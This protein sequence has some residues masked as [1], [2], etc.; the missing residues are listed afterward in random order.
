MFTY[1]SLA[2]ILAHMISRTLYD[3]EF[4]KSKKT[5]TVVNVEESWVQWSLRMGGFVFQGLLVVIAVSLGTRLANHLIE[6]M[7]L[8]FLPR[9][10]FEREDGEQ[11]ERW[12]E[13]DVYDDVDSW[14]GST[15]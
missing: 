13:K 10:D 1:I 9:I 15:T 4:W 14:Q 7:L 12:E 5:T 8:R 2:A 6:K 11:N 3:A